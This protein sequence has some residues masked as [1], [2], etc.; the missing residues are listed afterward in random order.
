MVYG[1][2]EF[3]FKAKTS[4]EIKQ[5]L[6]D[7]IN[8]SLQLPI[9]FEP[10]SVFGQIISMLGVQFKEQ[11]DLA[12]AIYN[13][14]YPSTAEDIS[15]DGVCE[16]LGIRRLPATYTTVVAQLTGLNGT[17][18]EVDSEVL[19]ENTN[20]IFYLQN[21]VNISN[22]KCCGITL[23]IANL[24]NSIYKITL[25]T[26]V[27][28]YTKQEYVA[29]VV[30]QQGNITSP[31]KP[32]DTEEDIAQ[33]L[34]NLINKKENAISSKIEA[35][36]IN[37]IIYIK[38]KDKVSDFTCYISDS[39]NILDVTS[40]GDFI[41]SEAGNIQV[42]SFALNAIQTPIENWISVTNAN[43]GVAG[44]DLESDVELRKRRDASIKI[45]GSGTLEAI[46]ARLMNLTG[47]TAV[48]IS[49]TYPASFNALVVGG[50]D[51]EIAKMIWLSKGAGIQTLGNT[52]I[53]I[54]DSSGTPQS[55]KFSR[56]TVI[57]I[58]AKITITK[59]SLYKDD[60]NNS[61]KQD[62]VDKINALGV[63]TNVNYQ[64]LIASVY[65]I[66][67]NSVDAV[68]VEIGKSADINAVPALSGNTI[69]IGETEVAVTE[70]KK[71]TLVV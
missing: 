2:T 5:E 35:Q 12:Q 20:N 22:E 48:S 29:E 19:V 24:N 49:E 9:N 39:I 15:L 54:N 61:I 3:G 46:K 68:V 16:L 43:A 7:S 21:A 36:S 70:L 30:D 40:N 42:P 60:Y 13:S 31:A 51:V 67:K 71:I 53:V 17:T 1:V 38:S 58:T 56:A 69:L 62:I 45:T 11:W 6:Q 25:D 57:Y 37:N 18:V 14:Q 27:I 44:V 41:A 8:S 23:E 4:D 33:Q 64:L 47:V 65:T 52:T 28:S 34:K 55:I 32:A 26:T 66:A 50:D 10:P 63:N 59:N